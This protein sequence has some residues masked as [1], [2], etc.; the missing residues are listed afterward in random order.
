MPLRLDLAG[1]RF[2]RL[3]AIRLVKSGKV[4]AHWEC[5]C[6]CGGVKIV[7]LSNL[8]Q[9]RTHSCGC[10]QREFISARWH[11][12]RASSWR[13]GE[14]IPKMTPEYRAWGN[15]IQRCEYP[16]ARG[17]ENYGGRGIKVCPQWRADYRQFLADLGRRPSPQHSLDRFP[18]N[19]GNYEPGNVRWATKGEQNR[20]QR[21]GH[22]ESSPRAPP[23]D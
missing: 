5:R 19:D 11:D 4:G 12:L 9:G 17:F 14:T 20:N 7:A 6:D 1:L 2:G 22:N 18:D 21:R 13:H 10:L 3:T 23:R 16:R 8:R 15:M